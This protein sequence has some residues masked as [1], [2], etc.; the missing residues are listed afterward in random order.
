MKI[1]FLILKI[2]LCLP[3]NLRAYVFL[4]YYVP[5]SPIFLITYIFNI[6][7]FFEKTLGGSLRL[8]HQH[9][10]ICFWVEEKARLSTAK[11]NRIW[12]NN[13][14]NSVENWWKLISSLVGFCYLY[15]KPKYF[16]LSKKKRTWKSTVIW[17]VVFS[18]VV[19]S[20]L[21]RSKRENNREVSEHRY[22]TCLL[23][24]IAS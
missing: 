1:H 2:R 4:S 14:M 8:F 20:K 19:L 15:F 22:R 6:K 12:N 9:H 11:Q 3:N 23:F 24:C 10:E 5:I 16:P 7:A 13:L 17:V 18:I 21:S